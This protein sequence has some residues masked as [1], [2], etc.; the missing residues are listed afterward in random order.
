MSRSRIEEGVQRSIEAIEDL[1]S[2]RKAEQKELYTDARDAPDEYKAIICQ[3]IE[4]LDESIQ[5]QE[6]Y[7]EQANKRLKTTH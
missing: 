1:R 4:D 3:R 7:I 5:R 2:K 6:E